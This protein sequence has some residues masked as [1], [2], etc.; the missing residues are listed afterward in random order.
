MQPDIKHVRADVKVAQCRAM[1]LG[2]KHKLPA[3]QVVQARPESCGRS[4]ISYQALRSEVQTA[5][6]GH[7][8][9]FGAGPLLAIS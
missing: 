7:M 4:F 5:Y 2:R 6:D 1:T 8:S 9:D 3:E